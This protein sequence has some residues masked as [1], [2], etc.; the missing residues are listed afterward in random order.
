[1][2][3]LPLAGPQIRAEPSGSKGADR[4]A[5]LASVPLL[6]RVPETGSPRTQRLLRSSRRTGGACTRGEARRRPREAEHAAPPPYI[7]AE[8]AGRRREARPVH[9]KRTQSPVTGRSTLPAEWPRLGA[10][11]SFSQLSVREMPPIP[12]ACEGRCGAKWLAKGCAENRPRRGAGFLKTW[13]AGSSAPT[14]GRARITSLRQPG[15]RQPRPCQ[16][17]RWRRAARRT[18]CFWLWRPPAMTATTIA[19]VMTAINPAIA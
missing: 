15:L 4:R 13:G 9:R 7:V 1:M 16:H 10:N 2:S 3:A 12:S 5:R 19:P 8:P 14:T 18:A 6:D 11:R 17:R